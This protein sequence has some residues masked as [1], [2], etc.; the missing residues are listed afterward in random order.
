MVHT[1]FIPAGLLMIF[2]AEA[3]LPPLNEIYR[4]A[5]A[6]AALDI[7]KVFSSHFQMLREQILKRIFVQSVLIFL[8][9]MA[10]YASPVFL[11]IFVSVVVI[12]SLIN[13]RMLVVRLNEFQERP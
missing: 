9:V 5:F 6:R 13:T 3:V 11:F 2:L 1:L 10:F 7:R 8:M 12:Y 4:R